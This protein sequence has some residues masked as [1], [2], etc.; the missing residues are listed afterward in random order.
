MCDG[1]AIVIA[2]F[3]AGRSSSRRGEGRLVLVGVVRDGDGVDHALAR[4]DRGRRGGQRRRQVGARKLQRIDERPV[5][6]LLLQRRVEQQ[7]RVDLRRRRQPRLVVR[8]PPDRQRHDLPRLLDGL[9]EV[10]V[11][12]ADRVVAAGRDVGVAGERDRVRAGEAVDAV[13]QLGGRLL[14]P[15]RREH[16]DRI[17]D[18]LH[19]RVLDV[20]VHLVA[21]AVERD[22]AALEI[23]HDGEQRIAVGRVRRVEVVDV[24][25]RRRAGRARGLQ[26]DLDV[27]RP[28]DVEPG[29]AA[30]AVRPVAGSTGS[31][32]TSQIGTSFPKCVITA[33]M[34]CCMRWI[35]SARFSGVGVIG[36]PFASLKTHAGVWLCQTSVWPRTCMLLRLRERDLSVGI[37]EDEVA[38]GRLGRVPLHVVARGDAVEV[39]R[40]QEGRLALDVGRDD[41]GADDREERRHRLVDR[42]DVALGDGRLTRR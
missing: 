4:G 22:A 30:V 11:A 12:V 29:A 17:D 15:G 42:R 24:E 34:W 6:G 2:T 35:S 36:L 39:L 41:G 1:I 7:R 38:L 40:Q 27:V 28:D 5:G 25:L 8:R 26:R 10:E 13:V 33:W 14:H 3:A 21:E 16:V 32:T 37:R 31:L 9:E 19:R 20:V 23:A 18:R